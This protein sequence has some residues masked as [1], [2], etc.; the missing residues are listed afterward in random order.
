MNMGAYFHVAPRIKT[1]MSEESRTVP[2]Q[3]A[4]A[5]RPPCAST[6]TGFGK[7]DP[8][9][10]ASPLVQKLPLIPNDRGRCKFAF[11]P[12]PLFPDQNPCHRPAPVSCILAQASITSSDSDTYRTLV[13]LIDCHACWGCS[14]Q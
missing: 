14:S 7:V 1:C 5:G 2:M 10:A 9:P 13:L 8:S 4:Y 6:A 11:L 3:L 12:H